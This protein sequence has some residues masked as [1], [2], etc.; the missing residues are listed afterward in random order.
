M[1]KEELGDLI[2][3]KQAAELRGVS[4]AAI[5]ALIKRGRLTPVEVGG[6]KFVRRADVEAFE[7]EKG[8]RPATKADKKPAAKKLAKRKT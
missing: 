8:G 5:S 3:Q 2:S 6:R 1:V 4:L 7:P